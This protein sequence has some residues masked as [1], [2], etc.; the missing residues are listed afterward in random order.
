MNSSD[1]RIASA[2]PPSGLPCTLQ[3]G[4]DPCPEVYGDARFMCSNLMGGEGVCRSIECT[5]F[6][7]C[8][9]G[10]DDDCDGV[11]D[12]V[13]TEVA[14]LCN[15]ADDDCDGVLDEGLDRDG[16]SYTW[17]N[18]GYFV[19]DCDDNNADVHPRDA[20]GPPEA[21]DG[22]DNDC[23]PETFDGDD[24]CEADEI[25]SQGGCREINCQ[26]RPSLCQEDQFCEPGPEPSC[27]TVPLQSCFVVP[28]PT[29]RCDPTS[30]ECVEPLARGRGCS[31]DAECA[32]DLCVPLEALRFGAAVLVP[33]TGTGMCSTLCCSNEDCEADETCWA[34]GSGTS[35]CVPSSKLEANPPSS[36][37]CQ[38]LSQCGQSECRLGPDG[39]FG[40]NERLSYSCQTGGERHD[41]C[42]LCGGIC[43]DDTCHFQLCDSNS[44]CPSGVCIGY[45]TDPCR[46]AE[47]CG[48][49]D[50]RP[51][52]P[53]F[54]SRC[55]YVRSPDRDEPRV[56]FIRACILHTE[57]DAAD[58]GA[59]C[60]NDQDCRDRGCL[61]AD[62][63]T[64]GERRCAGSCCSDAQCGA[65]EQCRPVLRG[66]WEMRCF[67]RPVF[68]ATASPT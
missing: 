1:G 8:G 38:H 41:D 62:G 16:D 63:D 31:A 5:A 29:G 22:V 14:E 34:S 58:N 53:D 9:N 13:E 24:A 10:M 26:T 65:Q 15:D 59:T 55:V 4:S 60:T 33:D 12:E 7:I 68:G 45:C 50:L 54:R 28:C 44:D 2:P 19:L 52:G 35:A 18:T 49:L 64:T 3:D 20:S 17:C 48:E 27:Q 67:P 6:E 25:C 61:D 66:L 30:G 39:A 37:P 11:A 47:D 21:C 23:D 57:G 42:T 36:A 40:L 46:S 51:L 32:T 56:D 43:H